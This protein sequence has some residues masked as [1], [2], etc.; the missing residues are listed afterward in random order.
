MWADGCKSVGAAVDDNVLTHIQKCTLILGVVAE[1]D[2]ETDGR[3][4]AA[5]LEIARQLDGLIFDGNHIL[6][7][8][9]NVVCEEP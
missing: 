3:F 8:L 6:N 1:P 4:S 7:S 5:I 2:F 9:G